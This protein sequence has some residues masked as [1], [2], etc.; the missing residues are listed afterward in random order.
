MNF[1]EIINKVLF[2]EIRRLFKN[3]TKIYLTKITNP[4]YS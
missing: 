2:E 4:Y 3:K 1:K